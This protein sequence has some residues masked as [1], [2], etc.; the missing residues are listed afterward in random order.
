M[1]RDIWCAKDL[2]G[3]NDKGLHMT[4][5]HYGLYAPSEKV[6]LC[7]LQEKKPVCNYT[8]TRSTALSSTD[9]NG[10]HQLCIKMNEERLGKDG[11]PLVVEELWLET[12]PEEL[13]T[14]DK[15]IQQYTDEKK[16][17]ANLDST[18]RND[19]I[20][21]LKA[22]ATFKKMIAPKPAQDIYANVATLN[23]AKNAPTAN[24]NTATTATLNGAY[25]NTYDLNWLQAEQTIFVGGTVEGGNGYY[26]VTNVPTT[27]SIQYELPNVI[28][29]AQKDH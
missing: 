20:D 22:R 29:A 21:P 14:K 7:Y 5:A 10:I 6:W 19:L 1:N 4:I 28:T 2:F 11:I 26:Q 16:A 12:A 8:P 3:S 25:N 24:C 23:G 18:L 15:T 17:G 13:Y 9:I 27:A